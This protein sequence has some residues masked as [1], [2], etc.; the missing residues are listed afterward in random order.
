[1][2][3]APCWAIGAQWSAWTSLAKWPVSMV[4]D[5]IVKISYLVLHLK[6]DQIKQHPNQ[7]QVPVE[8]RT[9]SL[10]NSFTKLQCFK[11][12][13]GGIPFP[14]NCCRISTVTSWHFC[15]RLTDASTSFER[16]KAYNKEIIFPKS[17]RNWTRIVTYEII[18]SSHWQI[19]HSAITSD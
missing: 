14:V 13:P 19:S 6:Y 15:Y 4:I 10:G 9:E 8:F 16:R 18:P 3:Y 12:K 1:M 17:E 11:Y 2:G 5:S 7:R